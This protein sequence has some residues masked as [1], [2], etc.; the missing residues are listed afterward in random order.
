MNSETLHIDFETRSP[1]PFG[2]GKDSVNVYVYADH[3]CTDVWCAQIAVGNDEP[4]LWTPGDTLPKHIQ[5]HMKAGAPRAAHNAQFERVIWN[6]ILTPRY[7]W[8]E[9]VIE[10]W[11]CTMARALAMALPA[12]LGGAAAALGLKVKK[13]EAGHR[14]MMQMAKPR[15]IDKTTGMLR[16]W[17]SDLDKLIRLYEYCRQDVIVERELDKALFQLSPFERRVFELDARMNDRGFFIDK[18]A[19]DAAA[20]VVA[21]LM[22]RADADMAR[23]TKGAVE[24]ATQVAA[25]AGWAS[26]RM[27]EEGF[28][29]EDD[30]PIIQSLAADKLED[31]LGWNLPGD[32]EAAL[33]LRQSVA[34]TSTAKLAAFERHADS[35]GRVRGGH[36]YAGAGR[37]AR[38]AGRG[39][40]IQNLPRPSKEMEDVEAVQRAFK[41][42]LAGGADGFTMFYDEPLSVVADCIRGVII[43][44]PGNQFDNADFSNIEGRG[45]AWLVGEEWKLDAFR[46][47]DRGDG[48]DLYLVAA[49]KT[50]GIPPEKAKAYRQIGKVE[51]LALGY[52]GGPNAFATMAKTYGLKIG[53]HFDTV[54]AATAPHIREEALEAWTNYG[55]KMRMEQRPWLAAEAIKRAWREAHPATVGFWERVEAAAI[56]TIT[57]GAPTTCGR[58][59]FAM[60]G[61]FLCCRLPSGRV[62]FYAA[63]TMR[64]KKTPWGAVKNT[65][66]YWGVDA[67]TKQW[68]PQHTYGGKLTEN[69][70]QALA[71]DILA[72]SMVRVDPE[73]PIV[74][75]VH[76]EIMSE[77]RAGYGSPDEFARLMATA[78]DWAD[79]FPL[80]VSGW[81]GDRY[82]K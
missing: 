33:R 39:A 22:A 48:P 19:R 60:Q 26:R 72:E 42:M 38:W 29:F 34:K 64:A 20:S 17:D 81:R 62:I 80:V 28:A 44:G 70:V 61:T 25:L 53:E 79:G 14:L 41:T 77:T 36:Q 78:P 46:A 58:V 35:D 82:R 63:P 32:V 11:D 3:I 52:G 16:W 27:V 5:N 55:S 57:T 66:Y 31:I 43:P 1:L 8:P 45:L 6:R 9:T 7:G 76:D 10:H 54:W 56:D 49:G 30:E 4:Q 13:D 67:L 69:I 71:R 73:Y 59:R 50:F 47:F 15:S 75:T 18:T 23:I 21:E 51:E 12:S 40:Q 68:S 2:R 65:L 37:T 74:M 24:R